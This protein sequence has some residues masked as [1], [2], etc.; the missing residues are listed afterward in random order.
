MSAMCNLSQFRT[1]TFTRSTPPIRA[2]YRRLGQAAGNQNDSFIRP[3]PTNKAMRDSRA[4]SVKPR[5]LP[6]FHVVSR[7]V[8][9]PKSLYLH[10]PGKSPKMLSGHFGTFAVAISFE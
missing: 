1:E 9:I 10:S 3:R 8:L 6:T 5:P 7:R 2:A 4:S